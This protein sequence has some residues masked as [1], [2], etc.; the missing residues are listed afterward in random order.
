VNG[1]VLVGKRVQLVPEPMISACAKFHKYT[2]LLTK[3]TRS[4]GSGVLVQTPRHPESLASVIVVVDWM[5]NGGFKA[6]Q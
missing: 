6:K 2:T 3:G 5:R 4:L 1:G